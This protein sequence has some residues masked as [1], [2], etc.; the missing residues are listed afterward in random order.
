MYVCEVGEGLLKTTGNMY[1]GERNNLAV[2]A[3]N[4]QGEVLDGGRDNKERERFWPIVG[5][6]GGAALWPSHCPLPVYVV[7][8]GRVQPGPV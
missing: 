6:S 2:D 4:S 1:K 5:W 7:A 3:P 8:V